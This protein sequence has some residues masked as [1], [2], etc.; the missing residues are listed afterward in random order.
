MLD[1]KTRVTIYIMEDY[2]ESKYFKTDRKRQAPNEPQVPKTRIY[3]P[4]S[5]EGIAR[6]KEMLRMAKNPP[7]SF[8]KELQVKTLSELTQQ[9]NDKKISFYK[10]NPNERLWNPSPSKKARSNK[11]YGDEVKEKLRRLSNVRIR[12]VVPPPLEENA[13]APWGTDDDC[14]DKEVSKLMS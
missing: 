11:E 12:S 14:D 1:Y 6:V 10:P 4:V 5:P 8:G 3:Q 9:S 13:Q 7:R 2:T